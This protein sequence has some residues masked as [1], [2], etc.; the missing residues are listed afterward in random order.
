MKGDVVSDSSGWA[1][2]DKVKDH[3]FHPRNFMAGE[4]REGDFDAVG[5]A[6]SLACGD[7][8]KMWI[9]IDPEQDRVV[10]LKWRTF[11]CAS[12]LAATSVFSEMVLKN[13]GLK[14]SEVIKI[15]PQDI[16]EELGGLPARKAHCSVLADKAFRQTLNNY[17]RARGEHQRIITDGSKIID[18]DLNITEQDIAN[19]VRGGARDLA[20]VQ[21]RLKAG[22]GNPRVRAKI[23]RLIEFYRR[24]IGNCPGAE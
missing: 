5:Q 7:I 15:T 16:M 10:D 3:F 2:S 21:D 1:Y 14:I 4:P 24:Q 20:D 18:A 8:M 17:F 13:G 9:K 6:G 11:G 19:A 22:V 12:A 23:E